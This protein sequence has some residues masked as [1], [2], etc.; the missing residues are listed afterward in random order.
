VPKEGS[1]NINIGKNG[2]HKHSW[3]IEVRLEEFRRS[4]G[5]NVPKGQ[6]PNCETNP[7]PPF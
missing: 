4:Q 2:E 7:Y 6:M 5:Q 1:Q 3:D